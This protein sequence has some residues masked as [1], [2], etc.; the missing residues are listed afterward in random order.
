MFI[1]R[2]QT[3]N[4][5][6]LR[7][8]GG[9]DAVF[10]KSAK[11]V[12]NEGNLN[13]ASIPMPATTDDKGVTTQHPSAP[14][15]RISLGAGDLYGTAIFSRGA[16][17]AR[18]I[19]LQ[20][21]N[22]GDVALAGEVKASTV[23]ITF[24]GDNAGK[25]VGATDATQT[26]NA[27]ILNLTA[28]GAKGQV[29]VGDHFVVERATPPA[30]T[31]TTSVNVEQKAT[32]TTS[33]L[34]NLDIH[35]ELDPAKIR[36]GLKSATGVVVDDRKLVKGTR[37]TVEAPATAI[38]DAR[39]PLEVDRLD[40][41][42]RFVQTEADLV[43]TGEDESRLVQDPNDPSKKIEVFDPVMHLTGNLEVVTKPG[44]AGG[45]GLGSLISA[46]K[47]TLSAV[48]DITTTDGGGLRIA[49]GD[50]KLGTLNSDGTLSGGSIADAG[51]RA[52]RV[53]IIADNTG[54][55]PHVL[56]SVQAKS[57][58]TQAGVTVPGVEQ[59]PGGDVTVVALGKAPEDPSEIPKGV[60]AK[61]YGNVS[62]FGDVVTLGGAPLAS[63][64]PLHDGGS[65]K[66]VANQTLTVHNILTGGGNSPTGPD[67][68][69][70]IFLQGGN[71]V[72]AGSLD[73]TGG[74]IKNTRGERNRSVTVQAPIGAVTLGADKVSISG[75]NVEV[76]GKIVEGMKKDPDH[77]DEENPPEIQREVAL[78]FNT[79]RLEMLGGA[80][81][82]SLDITARGA[83]STTNPNDTDGV[84]FSGL[85]K[86]DDFV[87]VTFDTADG[88]VRWGTPVGGTATVT[89]PQISVTANHPAGSLAP[90][91]AKV[92]FGPS[93]KFDLPEPS[94]DAN[95]P[96]PQ[97]TLWQTGVI[98]KDTTANLFEGNRFGDGGLTGRTLLL[99]TNSAMSLDATA[100]PNLKGT[101]L[102]LIADRFAFS[103]TAPGTT[104]LLDV[105]SLELTTL[106]KLFADFDVIAHGTRD[107]QIIGLHSGATGVGDLAVS[108]NLKGRAILLVAGDG[109]DP[110]EG[111][112]TGAAITVN[113]NAR[114]ANADGTAPPKVFG[115]E[116]DASVATN[117]GVGSDGDPLL[118]SNSQFAGGS[119]AGME[120]RL[121][122]DDGDVTLESG[123]AAK[124]AGTNLFLN[125]Q[126]G[127]VLG[128][129]ALTL[130]GLVAQTRA[131]MTVSTPVTI[132]DVKD[133]VI[134]L[135]AGEGGNGVLHIDS[136]LTADI[137]DLRAA[138]VGDAAGGSASNIELDSG[139]RFA[140]ATT[141]SGRPT[142]FG[143]VQDADL[144]QADLPT[145]DDFTAT[146]LDGL[147]LELRSLGG[148]LSLTDPA[149][150]AGTELKLEGRNGVNIRGS[151]VLRSLDAKGPLTTN[152]NI[153]TT[154]GD[155]T[156]DTADPNGVERVV[157]LN[158]LASDSSPVD[159]EL[160]AENGALTIKGKISKTTAG[161]VALKSLG[162]E[163]DLAVGD[164]AT[165]HTGG[166]IAID[167]GGAAKVG[168]LDASGTSLTS[169]ADDPVVRV[170]AGG[171]VE[172]AGID[173]RGRIGTTGANGSNGGN[174]EVSG[175]SL[176]LGSI[177]TSGGNGGFA[178]RGAETLGGNAG[179]IELKKSDPNGAIGIL[180]DL[181]AAG[182]VGVRNPPDDTLPPQRGNS[183][184]VHVGGSLLLLAKAEDG[185]T[186]A[187]V[188]A[189]VTI[190]GNVAPGKEKLT[191][192]AAP[193]D[194]APS[195]TGLRVVADKKLDIQGNAIT[196]GTLDLEQH[197]GDLDLGT[198][199]IH[200]DTI[201]LAAT[202]GT[203]HVVD[204][205]DNA[206]VGVDQLTLLGA[207][208]VRRILSLTLEQD[209]GFG[210]GGS[211]IP[212]MKA[213]R[214]H[215]RPREGSRGRPRADLS[216][217]RDRARQR[218][219]LEGHGH[220]A[221]ACGERPV[222]ARLRRRSRSTALDRSSRSS[223]C[224]S[225]A[226]SASAAAWAATRTWS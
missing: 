22:K 25:L 78:S 21:N 5:L 57:I 29:V 170:T 104:P 161:D 159:Q 77:L 141:A 225:A 148:Q 92:V 27:D 189:N 184:D 158:A 203:G 12:T 226:R 16:I 140:G 23:G 17:Q 103:G 36:L 75:G 97:F 162:G 193:T 164:V 185:P 209:R 66:L 89:A 197:T 110:A 50:V 113:E 178:S 47:G 214:G 172:V 181:L 215:R 125:G 224:S 42:S 69:G 96:R 18:E 222:A 81:V 63:G 90:G 217:R 68:S 56:G 48:G 114:F 105:D 191:E 11:G 204:D 101:D 145:L 100:L 1:G 220:A 155:L 221:H 41:Q 188:G 190:D 216:R 13:V 59:A 117:A 118:P 182:G 88:V 34:A 71:V 212:D 219:L 45:V 115:I 44:G 70:E 33:N 58:I 134:D 160:V 187:I 54:L 149:L 177:N 186:N 116:Q 169:D 28:T 39:N 126:T 76:D 62:L 138:G 135:S 198:K 206:V 143:M 37:L 30:A 26:L 175:A 165:A 6:L 128:T 107:D 32:L 174:V 40:L 9:A 43:A 137:I 171:A 176:R 46:E 166:H 19:A 119:I 55:D 111:G 223:L 183:N 147:D 95:D 167:A 142:H 99:R 108:G 213:V 2:D 150:V 112:N 80:D 84:R 64:D 8:E 86:A 35:S 14:A 94:N 211:A 38:Q 144:G 10:K 4:G 121:E 85:F 210:P 61:Q 202:D 200:S 192:D 146:T 120:Y 123:A 179:A 132:K 91:T 151:L 31:D 139:A 153:H 3:G 131:D 196:A 106:G 133:G 60:E 93:L 157:T 194:I 7:V 73:A 152:G 124:L 195:A 52:A 65:V 156:V 154:T 136:K 129:E 67:E 74:D 87:H 173:A 51:S 199:T 127:V 201:R 82:K 83:Q 98:D 53:T 205:V 208:G 130:T 122:S 49:A 15:G 163:S 79:N 207:N 102:K 218:R 168:A 180:G 72:L 109:T 24:G 20:A